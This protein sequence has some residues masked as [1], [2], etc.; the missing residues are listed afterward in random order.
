MGPENQSFH[1]P[2]STV[3][4]KIKYILHV[5]IDRYLFKKVLEGPKELSRH[6]VVS[7]KT[8]RITRLLISS[9]LSLYLKKEMKQNITKY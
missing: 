6:L 4:G 5:W 9:L 7:T 1:H 8:N 3:P 2:Q